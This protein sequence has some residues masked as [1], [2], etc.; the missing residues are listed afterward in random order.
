MK[1][2]LTHWM[3]L[4]AL[5]GC[6]TNFAPDSQPK[7][8]LPTVSI[9]R[10]EQD[11]WFQ[12]E[13]FWRQHAIAFVTALQTNPDQT[14]VLTATTLTGQELFS[15]QERAHN[16]HTLEQRPETK[17]IP[18]PYL[19]RDVAWV[20]AS[21]MAFAQM[22]QAG[23]VFTATPTSRSWQLQDS[24][25]LWQ[26]QRQADGAWL[27]HNHQAKYQLRLQP[28]DNESSA[29]NDPASNNGVPSHE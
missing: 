27:I 16:I 6:Q 1:W 2:R 9:N 3:A 19:Y 7:L 10:V 21:D 25:T 14:R 17:K 15:V 5:A 28:F 24:T 23:Y 22:Q 20:A 8:V 4:A 18:L 26:A 13:F 29:M 11:Q 12:A